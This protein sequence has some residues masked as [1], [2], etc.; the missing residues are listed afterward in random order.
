[1]LDWRAS[2]MRAQQH[3]PCGT[4]PHSHS[5]AH[6]CTAAGSS[7]GQAARSPPTTHQ[8]TSTLIA[9]SIERCAADATMGKGGCAIVWHALAARCVCDRDE[10]AN[11]AERASVMCAEQRPPQ[12]AAGLSVRWVRPG[13][14][15][16][17]SAGRLVRARR[18]RRPRARRVGRAVT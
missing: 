8:S 12:P 6:A 13:P 4:L 7:G 9:P 16:I 14:G 5:A 18:V 11:S 1:M 17:V 3:Q 10:S 2:A 15:R